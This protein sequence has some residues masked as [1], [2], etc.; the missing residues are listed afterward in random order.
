MRLAKIPKLTEF[1][2]ESIPSTSVRR[3]LSECRRIFTFLALSSTRLYADNSW[4][5]RPKLRGYSVGNVKL[6]LTH[7]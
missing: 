4:E 5:G 3:K 2:F 6:I 1:W 7:S